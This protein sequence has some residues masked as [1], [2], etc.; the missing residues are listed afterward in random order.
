M[1]LGVPSSGAGGDVSAH[2]ADTSDAH[3]ASAVSVADAGDLFT[4]ADA[5]AVLAEIQANI[6]ALP[7]LAADDPTEVDLT[8]VGGVTTLTLLS[9]IARQADLDFTDA[10]VTTLVGVYP[11]T[12]H[13][14]ADSAAVNNST[15]P[16]DSGL[17]VTVQ[18]N[19]NYT[20]EGLL[21]YLSDAAA[22]IEFNWVGPAGIS[23]FWSTLGAPPTATSDA[24]T[25]FQTVGIATTMSAA[26]AGATRMAVPV[27]GLLRVGATGG[28]F[29]LQFTQ[30]TANATNTNMETDSWI[31][32]TP[33]V[34]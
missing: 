27:R 33:I 2:L 3:D 26:G 21:L 7:E 4:G 24:V 6:N 17:S 14:L 34:A 29:K 19:T 5:E 15:T 30:D 9:T 11:Q 18:A 1:P 32:L 8:T 10:L 13:L 22:D 12:S 25:R 16:V 31:R 28:T 20:I 23:G